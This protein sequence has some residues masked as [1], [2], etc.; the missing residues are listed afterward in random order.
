ME[1][2]DKNNNSSVTLAS[3][4][5]TSFFLSGCNTESIDIRP[6]TQSVNLASV[7][8]NES[9]DLTKGMNKTQKNLYEKVTSLA[10][11][12]RETVDSPHFSFDQDSIQTG[13]KNIIEIQQMLKK[14]QLRTEPYIKSKISEKALNALS[15]L[16]YELPKTLGTYS[17]DVLS[18]SLAVLDVITAELRI[19]AA[20][21]LTYR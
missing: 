8:F 16:S 10:E 4:L 21:S 6:D 1:L 13:L 17:D 15:K 5:L 20:K 3:M 7:S 19:Q 12:L 11:I 2:V 18:T 9:E 14:D